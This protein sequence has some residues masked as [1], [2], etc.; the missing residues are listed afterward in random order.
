MSIASSMIIAFAQESD[1]LLNDGELIPEL[2]DLLG[3]LGELASH[4]A[5]GLDSSSFPGTYGAS[6]D[7]DGYNE[8]LHEYAERLGAHLL[9]WCGDGACSGG[10]S[11]NVEIGILFLRGP[12]VSSHTCAG[13]PGQP[14]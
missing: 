3:K 11:F 2:F 5:G 14:R 8:C 10:T 4:E 13:I 12:A 1:L 7:E 9:C 6:P